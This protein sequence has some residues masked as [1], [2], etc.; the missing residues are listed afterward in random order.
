MGRRRAK[1]RNVQG[2][3][4][5]DKPIGITSNDALQR[6][7]RLFHAQKAGHTGSL[8]PLADGLL[9]LCFG[10]ATKVSA[11]LLDADKRYWVRIRLGVKTTTA[12]A[13]GEVLETRPTDGITEK[14][15][16]SALSR[17]EGEIQ[18]IPPMYSAL[19]HKGE[20]LYKLAREGIEVEREARTITIRQLTLLSAE[21]PEFELDV[22]CSKGTYVRTLAED[23]GEVLGCGAHV[24][25]LRRTG[26]GPYGLDG[27]VSMDELERISEQGM[28]ALDQLLLPVESALTH[29]PEV[30]LS[31]D[32]EFYL[33]QGQPVLVPNAPVEGQVQLF[34]VDGRFI[35]VG[36]ILDDGRVAPR[37]LL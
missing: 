31:A 24:T 7:K 9:P 21:L 35:G 36:E 32:T 15:L 22:A 37:R 29:L 5:L 13:E 2:I 20:R 34:G 23:I 3:L 26:V 10:K 17:F 30:R 18:Q 4:L 14:D 19:K 25:A 16:H 12:D 28:D 8:D 27:L 6:V 1:G 33:K 11:F